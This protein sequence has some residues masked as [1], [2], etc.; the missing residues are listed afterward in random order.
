MPTTAQQERVLINELHLF[1]LSHTAT[2]VAHLACRASYNHSS[3]NRYLRYT[4]ALWSMVLHTHSIEL[5]FITLFD[6][7][8]W[9]CCWQQ[10]LARANIERTTKEWI[11][12]YMQKL[13]QSSAPPKC[14]LD[15]FTMASERL[16]E[17]IVWFPPPQSLPPTILFPL[18]PLC[19]KKRENECLTGSKVPVLLSV[20][21]EYTLCRAA[22]TQLNTELLHLWCQR[23]AKQRL[24]QLVHIWKV[25]RGA[26]I[27]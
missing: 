16:S 3:S 11:L 7:P 4:L 15:E 21:S 6:R 14:R 9:T 19:W 12:A 23:H 5:P 24:S 18:F 26:C 8:Y 20:R 17:A 25:G 1:D 10:M 22:A 27:V 2:A 13:K